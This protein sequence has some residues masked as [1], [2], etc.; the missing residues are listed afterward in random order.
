MGRSQR[1]SPASPRPEPFTFSFN[2]TRT[3]T[4]VATQSGSQRH[5]AAS[6]QHRRRRGLAQPAAGS[7][8]SA[9]RQAAAAPPSRGVPGLPRLAPLPPAGVDQAGYPRELPPSRRPVRLPRV[10]G[11]RPDFGPR[12]KPHV[13]RTDESASRSPPPDRFP[14]TKKR[15]VYLCQQPV[16]G[17]RDIFESHL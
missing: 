7:G 6:R 16:L 12:C 17:S 1:L 8:R 13:F 9:A 3:A 10:K 5:L 2:P 4:M 15:G 14:T 11:S